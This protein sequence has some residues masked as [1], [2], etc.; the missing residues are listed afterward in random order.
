M[1]LNVELILEALELFYRRILLCIE[2]MGFS[3]FKIYDIEV[4]L[5]FYN[6][7]KEILL[8]FNCLDF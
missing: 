5:F 3:F 6:F 2:D 8:C 7:Y 4:W 1:I